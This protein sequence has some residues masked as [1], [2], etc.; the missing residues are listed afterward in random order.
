MRLSP[1]LY[2]AWFVAVYPVSA[3]AENGEAGWLRYAPITDTQQYK[4]IPSRIIIRGKSPIETSA[5]RELQKGL[6]SILGRPFKVEFA[7]H[8]AAQGERDAIVIGSAKDMGK[9]IVAGEQYRIQYQRAKHELLL[10]GG[11][12]AAELFAAFHLLEEVEIQ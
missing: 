8:I 4:E 7:T 5:G 10:T 1:L 12:P 11:T 6:S 2:L 9:G 3:L